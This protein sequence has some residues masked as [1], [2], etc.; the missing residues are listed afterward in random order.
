MKARPTALRAAL[1]GLAAPGRAKFDACKR[2]MALSERRPDE[3]LPHFD[4]FAGLLGAENN[5]VKWAAF[6]IIANLAVADRTG[7][8]DGVLRDY[9]AP[10]AGPAM[11]TA[12]H[13]IA[14][15]ARISR[16]H[17][18]LEDRIVAAILRVEDGSYPTGECRNIVIGHALTALGTM[19][20]RVRRSG[21]VA[22]FAARQAR[23]PRPATRRKAEKLLRS[24]RRAG[25]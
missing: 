19:A 13:A 6:R 17:P 7:R 23:N 15:A 8:I 16:T 2:L 9:L 12:A 14:G 25:P 21:R 11:I 1:D 4:S 10:V 22:A 24:L 18:H 5:P 3:L 20:E